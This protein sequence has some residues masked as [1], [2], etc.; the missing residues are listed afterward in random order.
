MVWNP[1]DGAG[2]H[3]GTVFPGYFSFSGKG[4]PRGGMNGISRW[5]TRSDRARGPWRARG[6]FGNALEGAKGGPSS[7]KSKLESKK[8]QKK[9]KRKKKKE[10]KKKKQKKTPAIGI[11]VTQWGAV[12]GRG[13]LIV[14]SATGDQPIR[15]CQI[16]SHC[17][18]PIYPLGFCSE[19]RYF[20][21]ANSNG[22]LILK[23]LQGDGLVF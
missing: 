2:S 18:V 11:G 21:S 1:W 14:K 17:Y 23:L 4:P 13:R 16:K 6:G 7:E 22:P 12:R 8:K 3:R 19:S 15:W 5:P 10:G 20:I 9:K